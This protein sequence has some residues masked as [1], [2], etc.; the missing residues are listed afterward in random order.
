MSFAKGPLDAGS[1]QSFAFASYNL[2][3]QGL[4]F[5]AIPWVMVVP[6]KLQDEAENFKEVS[7]LLSA[8]Y[9]KCW[10]K[11]MATGDYKRFRRL[12]GERID[13][14]P[15]ESD[16]SQGQQAIVA[17]LPAVSAVGADEV[18]VNG[19]RCI[20]MRGI[21]RAHLKAKPSSTLDNASSTTDENLALAERVFEH[22]A[23]A[24]RN[25]F[26]W[27][28]RGQRLFDVCTNG[29]RKG[30][31]SN[32]DGLGPLLDRFYGPSIGEAAP[33]S[34]VDESLPAVRLPRG[35][36]ADLIVV[37]EYDFHQA[38]E[39]CPGLDFLGTGQP[40]SFGDAMAAAGYHALLFEGPK[41]DGA[42]IGVFARASRFRIG[43]DSMGTPSERAAAD[44][45]DDATVRTISPGGWAPGAALGAFDFQE[46]HHP[47]NSHPSEFSGAP[48]TVPLTD[49][50]HS[51]VAFFDVLGPTGAPTGQR[52]ALFG[53]HLMTTSRDNP[54][55][56][57]TA[58]DQV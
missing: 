22:V 6:S 20:T 1:G 57:G 10:H 17:G 44:C 38:A 26:A 24:N 45:D 7:K 55:K 15:C 36:G 12:W 56:V 35:T 46:T 51:A 31:T 49:R 52:V 41:K 13:E 5:G 4:A 18:E 14:V 43:R 53:V 37:Q 40:L 28:V 47:C 50:K 58:S 21:L 3:E 48:V 42:G 19:R 23:E 54:E 39:H 2:L 32:V 11:N 27:P 25:A 9:R 30:G 34:Q 33:T 8:E 29:Y 16:G